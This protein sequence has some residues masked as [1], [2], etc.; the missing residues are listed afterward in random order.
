MDTKILKKEEFDSIKKLS[1]L[2]IEISKMKEKLIKLEETETEYLETRENK[3]KDQITKILIDSEDLIKKTRK[4]Y[5]EITTFCDTTLTYSK[6]LDEIYDKFT[7]MLE[8]FNKNSELWDKHIE[9]QVIEI[10]KQKKELEDDTKKIEDKNK[11]IK[12]KL[13]LIEKEKALIESRQ[14]ALKT[15]YEANKTL[16]NKIQQNK[17]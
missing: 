1:D 2:S 5:T 9:S 14:Q 15:S 13:E 7:K 8:D 17:K 6:F 10:S 4:N 12:N 16:W 3:A 11:D